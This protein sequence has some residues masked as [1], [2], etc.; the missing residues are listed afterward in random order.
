MMPSNDDDIDE[1]FNLDLDVELECI[2]HSNSAELPKYQT[3]GSACFDLKADFAEGELVNAYSEENKLYSLMP[4][5]GAG[6]DDILLEIPKGFRVQVPTNVE[7]VI[8][9]GY[10]VLVYPRSGLA[11]KS[12]LNLANGVAVID[13]D[14]HFPTYVLL[15]NNSKIPVTIRGGDRIAQAELEPARYCAKLLQIEVRP[16]NNETER[17]GGLGST[18]V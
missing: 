13:H 7:F 6:I 4:F 1:F 16:H 12:G 11:L 2:L 18:G 8:P 9:E 15:V 17:N 14:Y 3:S 10:K 5:K